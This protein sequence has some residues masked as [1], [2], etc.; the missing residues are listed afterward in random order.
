MQNYLI[1]NEASESLEIKVYDEIGKGGFFWDAISA[2]DIIDQIEEAQPTKIT[3]RI[4]S[5]GGSV[6]EGL[7]I[8]N[9]LKSYKGNVKVIVDGLAAS[10]ASIIAMAGN[11]IEMGEGALMMIHD[12]LMGVQGNADEMRKAA[13]LLDKVGG[14][15]AD[16]YVNKTGLSKAEV[17]KMMNEETWLTA[18]EAVDLGF[19]TKAKGKTVSID[20]KSILQMVARYNPPKQITSSLTNSN[21]KMEDNNASLLDGI[22]NFLGMKKEVQEVENTIVEPIK[23][24]YETK[25]KAEQD[26]KA[27]IE[28]KLVEAQKD[29]EQLEAVQAEKTALEA[30]LKAIEDGA[31][32]IENNEAD[33]SEE[34]E[35]QQPEMTGLQ[36]LEEKLIKAVAPSESAYKDAMKQAEMVARIKNKLKDKK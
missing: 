4:N 2:Q 11:R 6:F 17:L 3:M 15:L 29:A 30:K 7:T 24:E 34:A 27:A 14:S 36:A 22:R 8:Y 10:I 31:K 9:Y 20:N 21:N 35:K 32:P 13:D 19:A 18:N 23:N 16:I 12:P 33:H 28:A 1:K 5:G 25:L 26:A